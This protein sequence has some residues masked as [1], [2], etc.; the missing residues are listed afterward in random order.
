MFGKDI[1][2]FVGEIVVRPVDSGAGDISSY[3]IADLLD[4]LNLLERG[5]SNTLALLLAWLLSR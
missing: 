3:F 2:S 1:L 5:G 4:L